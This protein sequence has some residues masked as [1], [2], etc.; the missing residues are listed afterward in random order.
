MKCF[1]EIVFLVRC[2]VAGMEVL[3]PGSTLTE[4]VR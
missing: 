3:L 1:I 4:S 2:C